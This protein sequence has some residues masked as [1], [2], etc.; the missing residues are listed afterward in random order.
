MKTYLRILFGSAIVVVFL[1]A[2]AT[3]ARAG[4]ITVYNNFNPGLN[5]GF[6]YDPLDNYQ[7]GGGANGGYPNEAIGQ[8]FKV[9]Q[10][11]TLS[12]IT[13]ALYYFDIGP[14]AGTISIDSSTS[15][16]LPGTVLESWNVSNLPT[17]TGAMLPPTT[18]LDTSD[19]ALTAGT[20]YFVVA[21][22]SATSTLAWAYNDTGVSA[23]QAIS[24]TGAPGPWGTLSETWGAFEVVEAQAPPA[25]EPSTI[26]LLGIGLATLGGNSLRR[27]WRRQGNASR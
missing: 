16:H 20:T 10:S 27:R 5:G 24:F 3:T 14:N 13:V 7:I 25:P 18:V 22:S 2:T 12:S 21:S 11:G 26:A 9:N 6:G 1:L 17:A 4:F 23:N 15:S 19:L 8:S